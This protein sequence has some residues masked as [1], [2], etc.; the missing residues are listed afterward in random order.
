MK[1]V[2]FHPEA[3]KELNFSLNFYNSQVSG[4]GMEFLEEIER[5]TISED[6]IWKPRKISNKI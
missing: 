2:I 1:D 5:R 4:L 3:Q 6:H